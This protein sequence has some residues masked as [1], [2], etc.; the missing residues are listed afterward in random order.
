MESK[1][2]DENPTIYLKKNVGGIPQKDRLPLTDEQ[3]DKP[4]TTDRDSA[5]GLI[6]Y[7]F[8]ASG[9]LYFCLLYTS[10]SELR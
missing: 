6:N 3:V 7:G 2:I 4:S 5:T 1:I 10:F 9:N 8:D